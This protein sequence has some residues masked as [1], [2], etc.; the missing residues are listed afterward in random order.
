MVDY[1]G[2]LA[3]SW[4]DAPKDKV[5]PV[6]SWLLRGRNASAHEGDGGDDADRII[7]FYQVKEPMSDVDAAALSELGGYDVTMKQV[8]KTFWLNTP[9][10]WDDVRAHL[11]LHGIEPTGSVPET[12]KKFKGTEVI[13]YLDTKTF[14]NRAGE[15][16]TDNNPISFAKVE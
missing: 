14:Q 5:L 11:K 7:F 4:E 13:A 15:T 1:E 16:I 6:G 12:L 10:D 3:K 9:R 8:T 2:L